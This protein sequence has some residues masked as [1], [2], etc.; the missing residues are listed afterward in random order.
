MRI[1]YYT[2]NSSKSHTEK[3]EE[4]MRE[5]RF[6]KDNDSVWFLQSDREEICVLPE[7][8]INYSS[9]LNEV[10]IDGN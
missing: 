6:L 8:D 1:L 4:E 3:L 7:T 10:A 2:T 5:K 9:V